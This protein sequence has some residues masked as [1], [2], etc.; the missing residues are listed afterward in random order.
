MFSKLFQHLQ[1]SYDQQCEE[2]RK[3][4]VLKS[5]LEAID[6]AI[7]SYVKSCEAAR[8]PKAQILEVIDEEVLKPIERELRFRK[9]QILF[10]AVALLIAVL[11]AV[12]NCEFAR[13]WCAYLGRNFL[14][15]VSQT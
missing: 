1:G 5:D 11:I 15:T 3:E 13:K 14:I 2:H 9:L 12:P 8:V 6:D 4:S 7:K 10:C